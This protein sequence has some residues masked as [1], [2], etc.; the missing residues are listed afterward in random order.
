MP[1]VEKGDFDETPQIPEDY[2]FGTLETINHYERD[3]DSLGL[4]IHFDVEHDGGTVNLPFFAPAKLSVS[5]ERESSRL[6]ENL[7]KINL[8]EPV[9]EVLEVKDEVLSERHKWY[10]ADE[11]EVENLKAALRAV[12]EG[13]R[14]RVNVEDDQEGESSQVSKL[15][16]AFNEDDEPVE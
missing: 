10:A 14:V 1:L 8:L 7:R 15:S 12:L 11:D 13:K 5:E 6:A 16:K 2:Y 3:A 9:L 4:V